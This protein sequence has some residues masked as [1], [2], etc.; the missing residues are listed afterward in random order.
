MKATH[1]IAGFLIAATALGSCKKEERENVRRKPTATNLELGINNSKKG[2]IG[3]DFHL[4]ADIVAGD[5]IDIVKV[6]ISQKPAERL[7]S[8]W[9]H[10]I[11]WEN[12]KGAKNTNVHK[13]FDIPADASAGKYDFY[14][15]VT[16]E[17]GTQLEIKE[18][19]LITTK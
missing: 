8:T 14:F 16:D 19:F 12:Y 7:T 2:I 6:I 18:D 13:H 1:I 10:Q 17:N 11:I 4:N 15:I 9:K 5:R 3:E